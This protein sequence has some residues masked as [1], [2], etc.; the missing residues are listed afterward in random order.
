MVLGGYNIAITL[1]MLLFI[2]LV[3]KF[4]SIEGRATF[5]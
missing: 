1:F 3:L 2:A 5:C 4:D